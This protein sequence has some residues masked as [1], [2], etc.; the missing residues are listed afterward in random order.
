MS[1]TF[2]GTIT[3]IA[4][5]PSDSQAIYVGTAFGGVHATFDGGAVWTNRSAG[6]PGAE[7]T[8]FAVD[9]HDA[10][11][12]YVSVARHFGDRLFRSD[13]GGLTWASVTGALPVGLTPKALAVDWRLQPR[14]IYLGTGAG[15]FVSDDGG[16]SWSQSTAGLPNVN[17]TDLV[18]RDFDHSIVVATYGRGV[19][20][21]PLADCGGFTHYGAP[22]PGAGGAPA[23]ASSG[24]AAPGQAFT[25]TTTG[26]P[27][28][29]GVLAVGFAQQQITWN[30]LLLLQSLD[31]TFTETLDASGEAARTF[32]VPAVPGLAGL[33]LYFQA[34]MLDASTPSGFA[35]S[36]GLDVTI[37]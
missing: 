13:D 30:G 8:D 28:A 33:H 31:L 22:T 1:P 26:Q 36:A 18:V 34:A 17:S 6:L 32:P 20:A 21:S 2:P 23:I 11:V 16:A 4:V 9:P 29:L 25:L 15:V 19:Y 3:A 7:V 24:C 27:N 35:A 12:C 37:P 5:A 10:D 14:T